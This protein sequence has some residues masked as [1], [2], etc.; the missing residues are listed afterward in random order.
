M[1]D[2]CQVAEAG[3]RSAIIVDDGYDDVPQ[4]DELRDEAGWDN[5]FD[6]V[7][8]GHE[9]RIIEFYPD[10]EAENRDD[11]KEDQ[12]FVA[13]LWKTVRTWTTY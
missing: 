4:V 9:D 8:A 10:F 2:Q 13:A 6:D 12:R 1:S 7:Q 11:L 5:F 3:I